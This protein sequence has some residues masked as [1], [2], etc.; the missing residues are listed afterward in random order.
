MVYFT[1]LELTYSIHTTYSRD[2]QEIPALARAHN[3]NHIIRVYRSFS[4]VR[5]IYVR[6]TNRTI[7][8]M[9]RCFL[10]C[11]CV[12]ASHG[13]GGSLSHTIC[14][15]FSCIHINPKHEHDINWCKVYFIV[16]ALLSQMHRYPKKESGRGKE[17]A[18]LII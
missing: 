2:T 17:N 7:Y 8:R 5:A 1:A 14:L 12:C 18:N 15:Y 10:L 3:H 9:F 11:V 4:T 6:L 16:H 13:L